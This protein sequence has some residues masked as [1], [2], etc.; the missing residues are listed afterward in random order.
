MAPRTLSRRELNRALLARQLLL[1]RKRVSVPAAVHAVGG[2]QSQEPR[3]PYIALWSRV[4]AFRRERLNR[5]AARREVVR[6]P[7]LRNTLHTTTPADFLRLRA[8]VQPAFDSDLRNHPEQ[9]EGLDHDAVV[10]A[11][12][13]LLANGEAR[14]VRQIEE[15]LSA[16]FPGAPAGGIAR[17][18]R[19]LVPLAI[20]PTEDRWGYSRPP[21]F[22]LAVDWLGAPIAPRPDLGELV[23]RGLAAIGPAS[24]AD[25][26]TWSRVPGIRD[27]LTRMRPDLAVF[28]DEA[29]RE[30]FDLP[31]APRPRGDTPAP[32][33]FFGEYD[34]VFLSHQDRSRI[35]DA[36]HAKRYR[37]ST[38][39]RRSLTFTY[40][41]FV[42]GMW[43]WEVKRG[44]ATIVA[45][46][47]EKLPRAAMDEIDAE[48][49]ALLRYL[50][51]DADEFVVNLSRAK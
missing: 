30:L 23:L 45:N 29:G 24:S 41:G 31:N 22:V 38:N 43:Q 16:S 17:C 6:A 50:E 9:I 11:V 27:A 4:S 1:E 28:R 25:L 21:R 20:A 5:A 19:F 32:V 46:T 2:L 3:D 15:A 48:A 8:L 35:I 36:D 12:T 44:V 40:D 37:I 33:R 26:R 13:E 51:P 18:A 14:T 42:G 49:E 39:G 10:A 7:L 34:N 47:L